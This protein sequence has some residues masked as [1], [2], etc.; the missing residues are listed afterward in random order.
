MCLPYLYNFP[1]AS[2]VI[3]AWD[4][5][6]TDTD[7][8]AVFRDFPGGGYCRRHREFAKGFCSEQ[9]LNGDLLAAT[10]FHI[11]LH[12]IGDFVGLPRGILAMAGSAASAV[13]DE[14]PPFEIAFDRA[15]SFVGRPGHHPFVLCGSDGVVALSA[16]RKALGD[17]MARAGFKLRNTHY[18]PHVTLLYSDRLVPE[19]SIEPVAWTVREFTLVRSLIGLQRYEPLG[20]WSLLP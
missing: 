3:A 8:Q 12:H 20:R 16:F 7:G 1:Y 17:A 14:I 11:S 18:T 2:T 5:C 6:R 15:M 4:R 9:R 13:C 19:Q 10:R